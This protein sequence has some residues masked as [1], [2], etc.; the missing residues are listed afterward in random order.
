MYQLSFNLLNAGSVTVS[1][2]VNFGGIQELYVGLKPTFDKF[3]FAS[4]S[5][6]IQLASIKANDS[7]NFKWDRISQ[8]EL[9]IEILKQVLDIKTREDGNYYQTSKFN[10]IP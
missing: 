5:Q 6:K 9:R 2:D 8:S 1:F 10:W 4:L 7:F 3:Y